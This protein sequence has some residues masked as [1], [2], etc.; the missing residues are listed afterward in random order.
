MA[1]DGGLFFYQ[2]YLVTGTADVQRRLHACNTTPYDEDIGMDTNF[3]GLEALM[4]IDPVDGS[5]HKC[6]GFARGLIIIFGDPAN[7]FS[8]AC[9]L[10]IVRIEPG[11]L[12]SGLE[13]FFVHSR[14][15]GCHHHPG[16]VMVFDIVFNKLLARVGA[17]KQVITGNRHARQGRRKFGDIFHPNAPGNIDTTVTVIESDSLRHDIPPGQN[18]D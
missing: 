14:R 10:E 7:M 1:A 12:A 4:I 13:C 5:G 3:S 2:M 18:S 6:F 11:T 9:H 8:N 15:A 17:H 16:E